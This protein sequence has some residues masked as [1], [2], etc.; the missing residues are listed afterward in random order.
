M[1]VGNGINV[2]TEGCNAISLHN[3]HVVDVIQKLKALG[4]DL[5]DEISAP[6]G[7]I[8]KVIPMILLGV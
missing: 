6:L 1:K 3:L 8:A 4:P 5:F 7:A 2:L